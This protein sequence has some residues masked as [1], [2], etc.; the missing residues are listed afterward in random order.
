MAE[1]REATVRLLALLQATSADPGKQ[2]LARQIISCIDRALAAAR[3]AGHDSRPPAGSRR[4]PR[5]CG[6]A[7]ARTVSPIMDDGYS[8]RKYGEK[9]IHHHKNPRFY[10]RCAYKGDLGCSARKQVERM[11][12]D[13]SQFHTAYFG[14]HTPACP[15]DA[16]VVAEVDSR[17]VSFTPCLPAEGKELPLNMV[18]F[19]ADLK[20]QLAN[21]VSSDVSFA[22]PGELESLGASVEELMDL[23]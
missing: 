18:E 7:R 13:P 21:L 15:R 20:D 8:W 2:E 14:E 3:G 6:E 4:R 10:F 17:F 12:E 22:S 5:G 11:E 23:L 19:T 16:L 1:A 9:S